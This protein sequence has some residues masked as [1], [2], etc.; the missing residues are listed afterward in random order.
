MTTPC[1]APLRFAPHIHESWH[2]PRKTLPLH[3]APKTTACTLSQK[4]HLQ[5]ALDFALHSLPWLDVTGSTSHDRKRQ[6]VTAVPQQDAAGRQN[7]CRR[8]T[9]SLL[10][11]LLLLLSPLLLLALIFFTN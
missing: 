6:V 8:D 7:I 1:S 10:P 4:P 11:L 5:Y 9:L 2:Q 3:A